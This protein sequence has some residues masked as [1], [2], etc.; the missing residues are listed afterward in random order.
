[1]WPRMSR[2]RR[3]GERTECGIRATL[4]QAVEAPLL[5]NEFEGNG[6]GP[7]NQRAS[8]RLD[9]QRNMA[10]NGSIANGVTLEA[11]CGVILAMPDKQAQNRTLT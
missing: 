9:A 8:F 3:H 10:D 5:L 11:R 1:M 6:G 7:L 2:S 4:I